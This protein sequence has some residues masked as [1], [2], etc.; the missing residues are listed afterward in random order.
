M[1]PND[2]P[3]VLDIL[4]EDDRIAAVSPVGT[5]S[6]TN[7]STIMIDA[8]SCVVMPGLINAHTHTPM[9]L[10]RSTSD[11]AGYPRAGDPAAFPRGKD[12][13]G[14]LNPDDRRNGPLGNNHV[15][16]HVP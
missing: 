11:D 14:H 7:E 8:G 9:T 6:R 4:I 3:R 12:W 2:E 1:V 10:T 5:S 13:R 16:G 15:R